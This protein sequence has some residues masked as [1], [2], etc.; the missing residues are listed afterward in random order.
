MTFSENNNIL[1]RQQH[2]FR[3]KHSCES[4]LLGLAEDLTSCLEKGKQTDV[5]VLDFSKAFDKVSHSLLIHK[6]E[7][8]GI[9]GTVKQ[10]IHNFLSDRRQ[11]VVVEGA[12]ST[13]VAVDSGVPQGTVLGPCLFLHY[14]NDLPLDLSCITRLFADD[15][16]CHK[17][18]SS[19][20]D[21]QQLQQDL[22]KL[23]A[24]EDRWLMEFHPRKCQTLH[25]TRKRE[26]L[27]LDYS[28][29][30]HTLASPSETKYL[31]V[32]ISEDLSWDAHIS[33]VA[34]KA[35]RTLGFLRRNLKLGSLKTKDL[36]YKA[37]VRPILEYASTVWDPHT[38]EN[39]KELEAVQRRAARWTVNR[40][41]QTSS[42]TNMITDL[43]W[44]SLQSRRQKARLISFYK[45]HHGHLKI[46]IT[47]PP[48]L[49]PPVYPTRYTHRANY[50]LKTYKTNY[51]QGSFFPRTIREWNLLPEEAALAP[52]VEA[53]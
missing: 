8:Y 16:M 47:K 15:T 14:I 49:Q 4:Q 7:H 13:E 12:T 42:V 21:S 20:S 41:R 34:C 35:N 40:Y 2:G 27:L 22:D 5:I 31:G 44:S 51:R 32:T 33:D 45:Y 9:T 24:W 28:L 26:P 46:N 3:S 43:N 6:L 1:C 48:K 17:V 11:G 38:E 53:F 23:A 52:S 30:G 50:E 36:A 10:W 18:I 37:L 29:H 19:P 39:I 25:V